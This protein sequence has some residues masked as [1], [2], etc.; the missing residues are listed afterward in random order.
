MQ[1]YHTR[2][3]ARAIF[4]LLLTVCASPLLP[5]EEAR[6][7]VS[8]DQLFSSPPRESRP[9]GY[10]WWLYNVDKAPGWNR[11]GPWITP[12]K[13]S[14]WFLQS[15]ITLQGPMKF[16]DSLLLP[17]LTTDI[18]TNRSSAWPIS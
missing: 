17:E 4:L 16:H 1:L 13:A 15:E 14:R 6:P 7:E 18:T 3:K 12:D 2:M 5:Q 11:G 10:W 8:L 9:S